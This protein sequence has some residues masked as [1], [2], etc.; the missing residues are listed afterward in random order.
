VG[1]SDVRARPAFGRADLPCFGLALLAD[2]RLAAF[3][4]ALAG[5]GA[6]GFF[7]LW[8]AFF[9]DFA[10]KIK[11]RAEVHGARRAHN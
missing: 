3:F 10:I 2:G 6:A 9:F 8:A 4:A 1:E 5:L 7:A 11:S